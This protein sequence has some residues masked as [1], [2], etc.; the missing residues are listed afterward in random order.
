MAVRKYMLLENSQ[1]ERFIIK[2]VN[3]FPFLESHVNSMSK[4]V[5][6]FIRDTP[7]RFDLDK[8]IKKIFYIYKSERE[9]YDHMAD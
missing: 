8:I 2:L 5:H 1:I 3:F 6:I 7:C 4:I 9:K